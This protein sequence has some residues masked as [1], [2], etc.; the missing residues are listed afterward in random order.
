MKKRS[1]FSSKI[2]FVFVAAG[3][4]VG[5]GNLWRFPYLAAKY[6]GGSFLLVYLLLAVTFGFTLMM[7]EIAIGRKTGKSAVLAYRDLNKKFAFNGY[8]TAIIPMLIFPYYTIINGWVLKYFTLFLTGN[9][10][11]AVTDGYF[12]SFIG[13]T[14]EP[15]V[16]FLICLL[17][18]AMVI[19]AG[20]ESG[21][22]KICKVLMPVLLVLM[23]VVAGYISIQPGAMEG[24]SYYLIPN[25]ANFSAKTVLAAM[26][27]LFYSLSLAMGIMITYGSYLTKDNHLEESIKQIEI[28]DSSVAFLSGMMIIPAVFAFA[29]GTQETLTAGPALMFITLPKAFVGMSG[30]R[31]IGTSF[32]MMVFLAALTSSIALMEA[33]TS[34][35]MDLF[36]INRR[37]ATAVTLL[38]AL[39]FGGVISL[40]YGPLANV[41]IGG[42]QLLDFVDFLS[43]SILMPIVAI[44]T[45]IFVGFVLKPETIIAEIEH[46]GAQFKRKKM[47]TIMIKYIAPWLMLIVLLSSI[48]Q[49]LGIISL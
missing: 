48:A 36:G 19:L 37:T 12:S 33:V 29:G 45:C 8:L 22:E 7:T 28:F 14:Y 13:S 41:T 43:N 40:G 20:V 26:G 18:I 44:V 46:G 11:T 10:H 15:L 30:G 47:Y 5:L 25:F 1:T 3:S 38:Y 23:I 9:M 2:G 39:P 31:L 35:F 6:G 32:F 21:I 49:A 42:M 4:A 17:M 16:W 24:I 34:I 27:Q